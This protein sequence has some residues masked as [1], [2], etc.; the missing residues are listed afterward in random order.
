[1]NKGYQNEVFDGIVVCS[2][3]NQMVNYITILEYCNGMKS[4]VPVINVTVKGDNNSKWDEYLRKVLSEQKEPTYSFEPLLFDENEIK[5]HE[6]IIAKLH[7]GID[8]KY[9]NK[10]LVWNITGGQRHFVMAITAFVNDKQYGRDKDR[11]VYYEGNQNQFYVYSSRQATPVRKLS[12]NSYK[13]LN[14]D[15][16]LKLM[17]FDLSDKPSKKSDAFFYLSS[18][19]PEDFKGS[20][21]ATP[22]TKWEEYEAEKEF[23]NDFY[24][25][26]VRDGKFEILNILRRTNKKPDDVDKL[27]IDDMV[28]ELKGLQVK[29]LTNLY[30]GKTGE[31][32]LRGS[33][34]SLVNAKEVKL[35][36]YILEYMMFYQLIAEIKNHKDLL[37]NVADIRMSAKVKFTQ[38]DKEKKLGLVDEFDIVLLSKSGKMTVFE[39]KSGGF[40]GNDTKSHHYSTY[41]IAGV[42]G[43]P[44]LI[45]PWIKKMEGN[46]NPNIQRYYTLKDYAEKARIEHWPLDEIHE[47]IKKRL[48]GKG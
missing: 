22:G 2:T 28:N 38:E 23:Y 41:A 46:K 16:A 20:E 25:E 13:N 30:E 35:F 34:G 17:G 37:D 21:Q 14:I 39:C 4:S 27:R 8:A 1:M 19:S 15:I 24:K 45:T 6:T 11:I 44:I 12:D 33:L 18:N 9:K 10:R 26:Y 42:Y 31:A 40:D 3:Q 36:G 29:S 48:N 47:N 5:N 7:S 43:A 32:V